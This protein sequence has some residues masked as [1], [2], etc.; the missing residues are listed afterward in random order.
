MKIGLITFYNNLNYGSVLQAY[1]LKKY[2]SENSVDAEII[3][4]IDQSIFINRKLKY[5]TYLHRGMASITS[6]KMIRSMVH[7]KLV[8]RKSVVSR[9][10][11]VEKTYQKFIDNYL[12]PYVGDYTAIG[13]FDGFIC[14]SDQ[15]WKVAMPGLHEVFFLR[16]AEKEKRIAY[17]VSLGGTS[18]PTCN[19]RRLKKYIEE[20]S[21]ISVREK[22]SIDVLKSYGNVE[23]E[24]VLDP[25]LLVKKSTWDKLLDDS[26]RVSEQEYILCYFLDD[27]EEIHKLKDYYG[28]KYKILWIDTGMAVPEFAIKIVPSPEEFIALVKNACYVFTDSFHA[29]VFSIIFHKTFYARR[30]NYAAY[31]EQHIRV[32]ELLSD[33]GLGEQIVDSLEEIN[34]DR[35]ITLEKYAAADNLLNDRRIKSELFLHNALRNIKVN[36]E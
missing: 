2:L 30:R 19:Q 29:C 31:P 5:K 25:T 32:K 18:V 33:F 3:N 36:N 35:Q 21:E 7:G 15:V 34:I 9:D 10:V 28:D 16:F 22:A 6:I 24:H 23:I 8:A 26:F 11:E 27:I 20:F 13:K 4:Y 14:G 17:A 12:K 1:A